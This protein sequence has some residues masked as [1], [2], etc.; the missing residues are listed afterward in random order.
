MNMPPPSNTP[1]DDP[2]SRPAGTPSTGDA[3][4]GSSDAVSAAARIASSIWLR[5]QNDGDFAVVM[6][7]RQPLSYL[8]HVTA[9]PTT[10]KPKKLR[11]T[12][13]RTCDRCRR[14]DK[15]RALHLLDVVVASDLSRRVYEASDTTYRALRIAAQDYPPN[16]TLYRLVRNGRAGDNRTTYAALPAG[17]IPATVREVTTTTQ[18]PDLEALSWR[19]T[20]ME[21]DGR[22]GAALAPDQDLP[23]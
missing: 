22:R 3:F 11:C 10:R 14:G 9:D 1:P 19:D 5:L 20:T 16:T 15:P 6:L 23:F 18:A 2:S 7:V 17:A 12:D 8:A 13:P 21:S 4:W